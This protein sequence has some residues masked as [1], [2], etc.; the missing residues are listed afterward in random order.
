M[1]CNTNYMALPQINNGHKCDLILLLSSPQMEE[2]FYLFMCQYG[3]GKSI[4]ELME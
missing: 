4:C 3:M 1:Q 2:T